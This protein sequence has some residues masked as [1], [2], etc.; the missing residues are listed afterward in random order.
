VLRAD[1][2]TPQLLLEKLGKFG[3]MDRINHTI[4]LIDDSPDYAKLVQ[5]WIAGAAGETAL[6]LKQAGTLEAGL[7]QVAAGGIDL[8]LLDLNLPDSSGFNTFAV[9]RASALGIP[10][11]VLSAVDTEA[12]TL[13]TIHEGAE[14]YL[15]KSSCS[16]ELLLRVV[17]SA[18]VRHKARFSMSGAAAPSDRP[19][20]I[21]VVA[22][23]GG[24]GATTVAC[25]LAAQLHRQTSGKVLLA[26]LNLHTGSIS[27]MMGL[28]KAATFSIRDAAANLHRLDQS[29]WEGMVTRGPADLHILLSP[30]LLGT[31]DLP[32]D[33]ILQ[34]LNR[35]KP[36]YRWIVLDLG[37]LN[38]CSMGLLHSVDD[39]L[40]V[41]TTAI[42]SLYGAILVVNALKGAGVK[43]AQLSLIVNQIG[44]AQPLSTSEIDKL[45]G[46]Q[47]AATLPAD[48]HEMEKACEQK[49]LPDENSSFSKQ[50]ATL[51]QKVSG[52]PKPASAQNL[53]PFQ[54]VARRFR[55][56]PVVAPAEC[57]ANP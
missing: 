46:I 22:A 5:A 47:I 4:L 43:E 14:D 18:I 38:A 3:E 41:T 56:A 11:V 17:E 51:A 19:R 15:V 36:F 13:Q 8:I 12:I 35:I 30:D 20:V 54:W 45:L 7:R 6:V 27:F 44:K 2:R 57:K 42:P 21:G 1:G 55:R 33:T 40:V 29:C 28:T 37:R 39:V 32:V 49:R 25:N 50:I 24:A 26:D 31:D 48:H 23:V 34:V 53:R 10:I 9:T 52:L 16:S